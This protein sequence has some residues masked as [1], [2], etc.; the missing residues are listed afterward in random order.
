MDDPKKGDDAKK[1]PPGP[2]TIIDEGTSFRG[3]LTSTCPVLVQGSVEGD[4]EGPA[5]TVAATGSVSGKVKT[6]ALRSIGKI[7]GEFDAESAQVAGTVA[8]KTV[9]RAESVQFK[10]TVPD[11]KLELTFK[12]PTGGGGS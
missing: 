8:S 2:R 3:S 1:A 4:L 6:G 5:L 7:A 12:S 9:V 10:L 11:G